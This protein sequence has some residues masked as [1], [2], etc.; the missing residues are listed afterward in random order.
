[1]DQQIVGGN[2]GAGN[3]PGEQ[4]KDTDQIDLG[5]ESQ[6]HQHIVDKKHSRD[7]IDHNTNTSEEDNDPGVSSQKKVRLRAEQLFH[8]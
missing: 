1:M 5:D 2:H 3:S 4:H 6:G 8:E 7:H